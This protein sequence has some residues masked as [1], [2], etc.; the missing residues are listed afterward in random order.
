MIL[1]VTGEIFFILDGKGIIKFSGGRVEHLGYK[2]DELLGLPFIQI[3]SRSNIPLFKRNLE[4]V[5]KRG[6][7]LHF[8][9]LMRKKGGGDLPIDVRANKRGEN[10][11]LSMRVNPKGNISEEILSAIESGILVVGDG[12]EIHYMNEAAK[13]ILGQEVK[14]LDEIDP[15]VKEKIYEAAKREVQRAE[16]TLP[17]DKVIG[18]SSYPFF[19]KGKQGW[20]LLFRDITEIKEL[21]K[22]MARLERIAALGTLTAGLAHEIRNPLAGM[23]LIAQRISRKLEGENKEGIL[24]LLR[25][26][27]RIDNL[28]KTLFS[29]AKSRPTRRESTYIAKVLEEIE[30]LIGNRFLRNK[31]TFVNSV[32]EELKIMVDPAHLEQILMNLFL[33]SIDAMPNGGILEVEAGYSDI[34][35]ESTK[36]TYIFIR[37]RDTGVGIGE[38]ELEKI[39]YPFYSTKPGGTGLGLFIVHQLVKENKGFLR[40]KSKRGEGTEF[41]LYFEPA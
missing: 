2:G 38:E 9:L 18:I 35:C 37:L 33:N 28:V 24:R 13:N 12:G 3:V 14:N 20:I 29:Y 21:Q 1:D 30:K 27:E 31:I 36:T 6:K 17:D 39:F 5:D 16:L 10:Y 4:I 41:T 23:K 32:P 11:V 34:P 15:N 19:H 26:I 22:I 40:V 8:K 25:Q 7:T